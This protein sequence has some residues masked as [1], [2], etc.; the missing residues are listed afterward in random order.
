MCIV[1]IEVNENLRKAF[2]EDV[3][4]VVYEAEETETTE[5]D[6]DKGGVIKEVSIDFG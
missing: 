2:N 3:D 4:E 1:K 5:D 6:E